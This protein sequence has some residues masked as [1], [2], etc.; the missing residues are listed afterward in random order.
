MPCILDASRVNSNNVHHKLDVFDNKIVTIIQQIYY[1]EI[2]Q[3]E[4]DE[5]LLMSDNDIGLRDNLR[6]DRNR[7][8]KCTSKEV[9]NMPVTCKN[10]STFNNKQLPPLKHT[11]QF[12]ISGMK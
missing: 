8:Q 6:D 11:I 7:Q 5:V 9:I 4:E 1:R 10:W 12:E 3:N 2:Y